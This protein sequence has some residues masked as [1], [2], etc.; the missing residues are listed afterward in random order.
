M[1]EWTGLESKNEPIL[2]YCWQY[3]IS[4]KRLIRMHLKFQY[5]LNTRKNDTNYDTP[6]LFYVSFSQRLFVF[7]NL[8][9]RR[10]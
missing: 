1:A 6:Q 7:S 10:I 5:H 8:Q 9:Y 2:T 4:C 3:S